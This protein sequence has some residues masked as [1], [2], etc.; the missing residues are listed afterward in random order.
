VKSGDWMDVDL[1]FDTNTTIEEIMAMVHI[2]T[3]RTEEEPCND[4]NKRKKE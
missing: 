4:N 3:M 2:N 1:V